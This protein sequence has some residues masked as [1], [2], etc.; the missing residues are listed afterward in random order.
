MDGRPARQP[1]VSSSSLKRTDSYKRLGP[2]FSKVIF[3]CSPST[4][5]K[6]SKF[7]PKA[8]IHIHTTWVKIRFS[9]F[10][11]DAGSLFSP[12]KNKVERRRTQRSADG[13]EVWRMQLKETRKSSREGVSHSTSIS[14]HSRKER[15]C[16]TGH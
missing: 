15:N 3:P 5:N 10:Q 8:H 13:K 9:L 7:I 12:H 6:T 1:T 14:S 16:I 2:S 11:L 4:H